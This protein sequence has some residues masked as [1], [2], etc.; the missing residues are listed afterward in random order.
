MKGLLSFAGAKECVEAAKLRIA[1]IVIELE[2][3]VTIE[4]VIPQKF[5]RTIMGSKGTRVQS[6]TSDYDVKIKFPEKNLG[7]GEVET[8]HV[9]GQSADG[10]SSSVDDIPK[11]CDIILIT[12]KKTI[13]QI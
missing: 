13:S 9:N 12:G 8:E 10:V 6:V 7:S 1:E 11:P 5:H 3:Q 2:Q 4:C